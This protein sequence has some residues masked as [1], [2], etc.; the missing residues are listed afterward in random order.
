MS[1]YP[2][3]HAANRFSGLNLAGFLQKPYRAM[4]LLAKLEKA[5]ERAPA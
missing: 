5:L 2:E 4:D 1:G 3:E